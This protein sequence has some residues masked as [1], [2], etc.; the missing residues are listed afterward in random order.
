M[1]TPIKLRP[2]APPAAKARGHGTRAVVL[3]GVMLIVAGCGGEPSEQE[4]RNARAFEAFLTAISLRNKA[5]LEKDAKVIDE[6]HAAGQL[7]DA[8][9]N[10]LQEML[11]KARAGDWGEAEKLAY[12]FRRQCGDRG[13]YFK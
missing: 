12:V 1:P 3:A 11:R 7:S 10:E 5:E 6:R 8:R 4:V 13:S 9:H 2:L